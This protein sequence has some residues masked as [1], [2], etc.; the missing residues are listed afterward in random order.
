MFLLLFWQ[1]TTTLPFI[2]G[3]KYLN[4]IVIGYLSPIID[5][6]ISKRPLAHC[7]VFGSSRLLL[8]INRSRS[9]VISQDK[10]PNNKD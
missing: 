5:L 10:L 3:K 9:S 1:N 2:L 6:A 7:C 4:I 8:D